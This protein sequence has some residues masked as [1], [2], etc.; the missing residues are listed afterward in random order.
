MKVLLP[1]LSCLLLVGCS[2]VFDYHPYDTRFDGEKDINAKNIAAIMA[3]P[4]TDSTGFTFAFISDTHGW[5]TETIDMIDDINGR[6]DVDFVIHGGDLTDVGT[7]KEF[8]WIRDYLSDL[9]V[10]YVALLGNHDCLGTGEEVYNAM[11]GDPDFSFIV[12]RV[13]FVCLNT[14]ATEYDYVASVPDLDYME[15]QMTADST[16]FDRTVVCMHARPYSDQFNNNIAKAFELYVNYMPGIMFCVNGHDHAIQVD[17]LFDDGIIYYG[18]PCAEK[19]AYL[20]FTITLTGYEYE[21]VYF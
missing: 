14:N 21:V 20:L 12:G 4:V 18:A 10:P 17:E 7:T 11:F 15:E 6:D 5:Y 13:K 3:L 8:V 1:I 2:D 16:D 9:D 19:R